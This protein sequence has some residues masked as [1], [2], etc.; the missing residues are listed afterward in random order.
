MIHVHT[1]VCQGNVSIL[2][3]SKNA[4]QNKRLKGRRLCS[5]MKKTV[6]DLIEQGAVTAHIHAAILQQTKKIIHVQQ[7]HAK[8][9]RPALGLQVTAAVP[10]YLKEN[11]EFTLI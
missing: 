6:I 2:P 4:Q 9:T 1:F 10:V 3:G 5:L 8:T 7:L 11:S